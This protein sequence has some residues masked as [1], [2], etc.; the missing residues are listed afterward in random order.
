[1]VIRIFFCPI[2]DK[3]LKKLADTLSNVNGKLQVRNLSFLQTKLCDKN[4]ADLFKR[5]SASFTAL[6]HLS[7]S[8]NNFTDI[9]SSF[10]HLVR[11]SQH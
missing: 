2:N 3:L 9:M 4:V 5:A 6:E 11:A 7:L 8:H 1:M 10:S